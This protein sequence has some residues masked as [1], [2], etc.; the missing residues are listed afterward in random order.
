MLKYLHSEGCDEE[1]SVEGHL[2]VL[3]YVV[4]EGCPWNRVYCRRLAG[5]FVHFHVVDWI[6]RLL[7]EEE[8]DSFY[9]M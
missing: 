3:Q 5:D 4:R 2:D 9:P 8:R 7:S 1:P 6:E